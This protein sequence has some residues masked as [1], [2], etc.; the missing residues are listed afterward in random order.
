M[1]RQATFTN[2]RKG[3][4]RNAR[5]EMRAKSSNSTSIWPGIE[6]GRYQPLPDVDVEKV[7]RAA[8]SVLEQTGIADPTEEL[9]DLVLPKGALQ[10]DHGPFFK[11]K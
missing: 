6:G 2:R 3:R 1:T 9:L 7:H 10:T 5:L 4:G 8:L 11:G